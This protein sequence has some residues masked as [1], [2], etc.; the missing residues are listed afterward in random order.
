MPV[1]V[2]TGQ[3]SI[4]TIGAILGLATLTIAILGLIDHS[5]VAM[6]PLV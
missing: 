5:P 4:A 1:A 6:R 3:H 2:P